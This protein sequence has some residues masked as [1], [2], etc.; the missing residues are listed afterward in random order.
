MHHHASWCLFTKYTIRHPSRQEYLSTPVCPAPVADDTPPTQTA[1]L[2]EGLRERP[3][4]SAGCTEP[5]Y[6]DS[7]S[8]GWGRSSWEGLSTST[9]LLWMPAHT[10]LWLGFASE[11]SPPARN[12]QNI[13]PQSSEA[14]SNPSWAL[15]THHSVRPVWTPSLTKLQTESLSTLQKFCSFLKKYIHGYKL[16]PLFSHISGSGFWKCGDEK[17]AFSLD[18]W[19]LTR[20]LTQCM[21]MGSIVH[22]SWSCGFLSS[23]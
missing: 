15:E 18:P 2:T 8:A 12:S 17:N 4:E 9:A 22:P 21:H 5:A 7:S 10:E 11:I 16:Y 14:S 13:R 19:A 20:R 23:T 1:G 3:Q 6:L